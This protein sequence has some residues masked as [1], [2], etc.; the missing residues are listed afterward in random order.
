MQDFRTSDLSLATALLFKQFRLKQLDRS[1][2]SRCE[3][4]FEDSKELQQAIAAYWSDELMCPAQSLLASLK[5]T[6]H[7]LYDSP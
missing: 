2:P 6:K 3:F 1:N 7:I 5:R 4:V